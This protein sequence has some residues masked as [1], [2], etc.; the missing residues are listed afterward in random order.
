MK[1]FAKTQAWSLLLAIG[2]TIAWAQAALAQPANHAQAQ[3]TDP[4]SVAVTFLT[5]FPGN[6]EATLD[7]MTDDAM[8]TIVPPPP[9]TSGIWSGKEQLRQW[10][11]FRKQQAASIQ[12]VGSPQVDGSKVTIKAMIDTN[13]FRNW[14]VGPVEHTIEIV[15]EGGKVKSYTSM[16]ALAERDRVAAAAR[17]AQSQ[18]Q[19]QAPAGMPRTGQDQA[20]LL[21]VLFIVS[22]LALVAG[23]YVKV[24]GLRSYL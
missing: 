10:N 24:K 4:A 7:L 2:L 21:A 3:A 5:G 15:V 8:A 20:L 13:N 9:G 19:S 6:P 12:I 14:G 1:R 11:V 22:A 18:S 23:L 16:M 17:A